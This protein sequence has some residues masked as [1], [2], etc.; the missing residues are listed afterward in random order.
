M[1]CHEE[2][3]WGRI[4][5]GTAIFNRDFV[6][7]ISWVDVAVAVAIGNHGSFRVAEFFAIRH[8]NLQLGTS[9]GDG[10]AAGH[11]IT[12]CGGTPQLRSADAVAIEIADMPEEKWSA[13]SAALRFTVPFG[14]GF[15]LNRTSDCN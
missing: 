10:I 11:Q 1:G 2:I 15:F 5:K 6:S 4:R 8:R 13:I 3:C 7:E 9:W 14:R 12:A